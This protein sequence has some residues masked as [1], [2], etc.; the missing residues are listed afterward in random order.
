MKKKRTRSSSP[1]CYPRHLQI[2][3]HICREPQ[4]SI[5]DDT[6]KGHSSLLHRSL[7]RTL[8]IPWRCPYKILRILQRILR[9]N[10]VWGRSIVNI[11]RFYSI[12]TWV[13]PKDDVIGL[14]SAEEGKHSV[15]RCCGEP[16]DKAEKR[17][18]MCSEGECKN[19][20]VLCEMISFRH[21]DD[22]CDELNGRKF[23][24]RVKEN[25]GQQC[26]RWTLKM[27]KF[28]G[29]FK[30]ENWVNIAGVFIHSVRLN[31]LI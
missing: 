16:L 17:G 22:G 4:E 20:H 18:G 12:Q 28:C 1:E 2:I 5:C 27:R 11:V 19:C 15:R 3:S 8:E 6:T 10:M 31:F 25:R 26:N 24:C 13:L 7:H 14:G 29:Y 21:G 23:F 9:R 30:G